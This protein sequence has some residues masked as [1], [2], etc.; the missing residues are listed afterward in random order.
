MK[1]VVA[2]LPANFGIATNDSA[3]PGIADQ[4]ALVT[5]KVVRIEKPIGQG[6]GLE[7][8]RQDLVKQL[9]DDS[10]RN[11]IFSETADPEVDVGGGGIDRGEAIDHLGVG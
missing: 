5:I 2:N 6:E 4:P 3:K 11:M 7:L 9:P 1:H 10:P 8:I